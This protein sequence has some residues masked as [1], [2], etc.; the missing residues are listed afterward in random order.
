MYRS[1]DEL[2]E[3]WAYACGKEFIV[4]YQELWAVTEPAIRAPVVMTKGHWWAMVGD[5]LK[6]I[7]ECVEKY[8][9]CGP[10]ST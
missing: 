3:D 4:K 6:E 10:E 7:T 8:H 5:M 1:D 9:R 2:R